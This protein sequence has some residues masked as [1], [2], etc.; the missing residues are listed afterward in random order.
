MFSKDAVLMTR[1]SRLLSN[2][3][4]F[5]STL[6]TLVVDALRFLRLCWRSPTTLAAENLFLRQQVALDQERKVTPRRA[7]NAT[8]LALVCSGAGVM[9]ARRWPLGNRRRSS[10]GIGRGFGSA[11][12]GN[13]SRDG[14]RSLR[15]CKRVSVV[16][17]ARTP[18][19]VKSGSR[20]NS[21]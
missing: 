16:W 2:L 8:R 1:L 4:R 19:G 17:L 15:T 11:G 6:L 10:A 13:R 5:A 20:T 21:C 12:P 7:T 18:R 14:P 3:I 9:G